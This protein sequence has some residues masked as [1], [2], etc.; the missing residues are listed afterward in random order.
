M[1]RVSNVL[2]NFSHLTLHALNFSL[3]RNLF[4]NKNI[5]A[6]IYNLLE[7]LNPLSLLSCKYRELCEHLCMNF[8]FSSR[9]QK[10]VKSGF[11]MKKRKNLSDHTTRF[12]HSGLMYIERD[13]TFARIL[14]YSLG[15]Y[16]GWN[17][18][19]SF[20]VTRE[21]LFTLFL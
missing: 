3:L 10:L 4:D 15:W 13:A 20:K 9:W 17:T 21:K 8:A 5:H 12:Q 14:S 11:L 19:M 18:A 7:T 1:K 6:S 16:L 2:L